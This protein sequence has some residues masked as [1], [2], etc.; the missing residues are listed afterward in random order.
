MFLSVRN[1]Q[2]ERMQEIGDAEKNFV[3]LEC[4]E[5]Q[6]KLLEDAPEQSFV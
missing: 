6:P 1:L 5:F 4:K 2:T 3:G